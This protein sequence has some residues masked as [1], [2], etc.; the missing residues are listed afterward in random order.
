M[1]EHCFNL[2]MAMLLNRTCNEG[3]KVGVL[4]SNAICYINHKVLLIS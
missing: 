2:V 3:Y 4:N 1:E